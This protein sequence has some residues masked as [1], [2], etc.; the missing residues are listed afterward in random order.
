MPQTFCG[1]LKDCSKRGKPNTLVLSFFAPCNPPSKIFGGGGFQ[2]CFSSPRHMRTRMNI[3]CL[4]Y[5]FPTTPLCNSE[6]T[7]STLLMWRTRC[8]GA[9]LDGG[10]ANWWLP[11]YTG[12]IPILVIRGI[13]IHPHKTDNHHLGLIRWGTLNIKN[14]E[15]IN[16]SVAFLLFCLRL[17]SIFISEWINVHIIMILWCKSFMHY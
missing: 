17:V 6:T 8:Q 13:W 4:Q 5:P 9:G 3:Y 12:R 15:T 2:Q 11:I 14:Q 16:C 10:V 1:I 7:I